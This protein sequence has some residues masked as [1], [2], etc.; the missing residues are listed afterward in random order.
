MYRQVLSKR[1]FY[2][3]LKKVR[4]ISNMYTNRPRVVYCIESHNNTFATLFKAVEGSAV[5]PLSKKFL[6]N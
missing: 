1:R 2:G 3:P 4:C 5:I 6:R